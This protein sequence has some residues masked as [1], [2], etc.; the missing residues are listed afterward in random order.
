MKGHFP[1]FAGL[2]DS[3]L[4]A[5][6]TMAKQVENLRKGLDSLVMNVKNNDALDA[7]LDKLAVRHKERAMPADYF[8]VKKYPLFSG[9]LMLGCT[10]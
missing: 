2:D 5:C 3:A 4:K 9:L 1:D 6:P 10:M 8:E 7:A